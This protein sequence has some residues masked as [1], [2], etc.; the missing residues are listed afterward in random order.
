MREYGVIVS[1]SLGALLRLTNGLL[2]C[3]AQLA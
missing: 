3:F 2:S 1:A